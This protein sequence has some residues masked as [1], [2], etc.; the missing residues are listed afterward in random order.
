MQLMPSTFAAIQSARPEFANI[1]DPE[2]N[3]A[4]GI[5]HDRYLWKL[6]GSKDA[7]D[8][9]ARFM[10]GSYNAGEGP[11]KRANEVAS[12]QDPASPWALIE[13]VAPQIPRW[14]YK[15]TLGYVRKIDGNFTKLVSGSR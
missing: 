5:M 10:F 14:R 4:A 3:I 12:T 8:D 11:I 2:W 15:E 7:E 6:W 9:R 13:T 1:N